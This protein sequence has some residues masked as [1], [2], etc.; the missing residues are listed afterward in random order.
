[1]VGD[2]TIPIEVRRMLMLIKLSGQELEQYRE[3]GKS[4]SSKHYSSLV[5]ET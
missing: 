1:M 5:E 4:A 3:K 2:R